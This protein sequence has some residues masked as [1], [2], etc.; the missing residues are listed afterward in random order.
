MVQKHSRR[1]HGRTSKQSSLH[2]DCFRIWPRQIRTRFYFRH[3]YLGK[4]PL[5][6][7]SSSVSPYWPQCHRGGPIRKNLMAVLFARNGE[8]KYDPLFLTRRERGGT[9]SYG[10]LQCDGF[11]PSCRNC[12]RYGSSC[13]FV[14]SHPRVPQQDAPA[15]SLRKEL[16]VVRESFD[17]ETVISSEASAIT[18]ATTATT[19]RTKCKTLVR[20]PSS[21]ALIDTASAAPVAGSQKTSPETKS[22]VR[23]LN[24]L[25]ITL[26]D[27]E[28]INQYLT[29]THLSI[30]NKVSVQEAYRK[31][32]LTEALSHEHLMHAI[33]GFTAAHLMHIRLDRRDFYENRARR[34]Q[35]LCKFLL[36]HFEIATFSSWRSMLSTAIIRMISGKVCA[37]CLPRRMTAGPGEDLVA[38]ISKL[39]R[40]PS[41]T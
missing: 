7:R 2:T 33:L 5:R 11:L 30:S 36:F 4:A 13:S 29:A 18:T 9:S 24:G 10:N 26:Y 35:H 40:L 19:N 15:P 22:A 1:V 14:E 31:T 21:L 23:P 12:V 20:D 27:E 25:L 3:I 17:V 16:H 28:L 8:S 37:S 41:Q 32:I 39:F 34:H 6:I 38:K